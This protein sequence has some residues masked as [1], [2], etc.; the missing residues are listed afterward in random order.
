MSVRKRPEGPAWRPSRN[1]LTI[2]GY[3]ARVMRGLIIDHA[4]NRRAQKRDGQFEITSLGTDTENAVDDHKLVRISEALDELGK[5]EPTLV[6]IVYL[7]FFCGFSFAEMAAMRDA[8]GRPL[9]KI[10]EGVNEK[11]VGPAGEA[12]SG[13]CRAGRSKT[14]RATRLWADRD[15]FIN[16]AIKERCAEGPVSRAANGLANLR[17]RTD[18]ARRKLSGWRGT[19]SLRT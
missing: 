5:A 3:A 12:R 14:Q 4:R 7:K 13:A 17:C 15:T 11:V 2:Y 19:T 10:P 18:C 8:R 1:F 16:S 9:R 6:Q